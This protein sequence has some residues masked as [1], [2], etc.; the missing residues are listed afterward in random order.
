M[1]NDN[2]VQLLNAL[3]RH[4]REKRRQEGN[5]IYLLTFMFEQLP[6]KEEAVIRQM[7]G[8]IERYYARVCRRLTRYPKKFGASH[9]FMMALH[10]RPRPIRSRKHG[11]ADVVI[12]DGIHF[13]AMV[14]L[15]AENRLSGKQNGLKRLNREFRSV[16]LSGLPIRRVHVRRIKVTIEKA[17]HYAFKELSRGMA[18]AADFVVLPKSSGELE[19]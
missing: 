4:F 9:F 2:N 5:K 18:S 12:N 17:V 15:S 13:H 10:D 8:A 1:A 19:V 16:L 3:G 7:T 6:G 14:A 11:I